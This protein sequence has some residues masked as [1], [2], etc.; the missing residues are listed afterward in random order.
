M[1]SWS[2]KK[3]ANL[4]PGLW[5]YKILLLVQGQVNGQNILVQASFDYLKIDVFLISERKHV[6]GTHF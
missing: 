4:F 1:I 3:N 2:N 6:V 5:N